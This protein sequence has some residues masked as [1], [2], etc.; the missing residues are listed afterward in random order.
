M[1]V[2]TVTVEARDDSLCLLTA[3]GRFFEISDSN[4]PTHPVH[5]A[6]RKAAIV[7]FNGDF[8]HQTAQAIEDLTHE[9]TP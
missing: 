9:R 5:L 7:R 4:L 8:G 3:L 2:G 6:L 1:P